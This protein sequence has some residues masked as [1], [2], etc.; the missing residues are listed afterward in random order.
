MAVT[1]DKDRIDFLFL[2]PQDI[3]V[4]RAVHSMLWVRQDLLDEPLDVVGTCLSCHYI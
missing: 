4:L 2:I 1:C 3:G